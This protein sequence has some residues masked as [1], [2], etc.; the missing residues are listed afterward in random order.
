MLPLLSLP[1]P[2][3]PSISEQSKRCLIAFVSLMIGA[4]IGVIITAGILS[5][6]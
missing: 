2:D 6:R 1:E 3:A 4:T 5:M